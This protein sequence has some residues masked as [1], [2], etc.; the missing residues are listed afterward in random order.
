MSP[1]RPITIT[2]NYLKHP[3]GSC[4]YQMGE[5]QV[6]VSVACEET[7]PPFAQEAGKGWITAEYGMLPG[8]A[9]S[10]IPRNKISSRHGEIQ[11]L[12]GRSLRA[13]THLYKIPGRTLRVDCDCLQADG[14][15]R[16]ASING[17]FLALCQAFTFFLKKGDILTW[18]LQEWIGAVSVGKVHGEYQVDLD[19]SLDS[20][21]DLDL[22][23][24]ATA[25]GNLVE[26]Q[27]TGEGGPFSE[28]DLITL[29]KLAKENIQTIIQKG[30]EAFYQ[31]LKNQGEVIHPQ[32]QKF[33]EE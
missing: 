20:Q 13:V 25:S 17:A 22:N 16:T 18:P 26:V 29:V 1:L 32:I 19:F 10:R 4:L 8:S 6:L 9:D 11:R 3:E 24:V 23:V 27:G 28:E 15:T 12:I 2:L 7:A 31:W 14:G 30:K 5:T 21:A 33:L